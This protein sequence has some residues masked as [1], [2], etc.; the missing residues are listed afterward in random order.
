MARW[1][2][3]HPVFQQHRKVVRSVMAGSPRSLWGGPRPGLKTPSPEYSPRKPWVTDH[4]HCCHRSLCLLLQIWAWTSAAI[5]THSHCCLWKRNFLTSAASGLPL[6]SPH[7]WFSTRRLC[8]MARLGEVRSHC[9]VS[10]C[11]GGCGHEY[12][13]CTVPGRDRV[14]KSS[15]KQKKNLYSR[16]SLK[17]M[18]NVFLR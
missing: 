14:V 1:V 4:T 3:P 15:P 17:G 10:S 6:A 7:P 12:L 8:W 11:Q 18:T 5:I 2:Y 13:A 16:M 9:L